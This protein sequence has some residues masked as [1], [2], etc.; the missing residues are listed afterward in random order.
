MK[1]DNGTIEVVAIEKG[2]YG[3]MRQPGDRFM[4]ND[5]EAF[6]WRW[7]STL[8]PRV[9]AKPQPAGFEQGPDDD[10]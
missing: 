4:I 8:D 2:F 5:V 3:K 7:M 9:L 6:S 1:K 10:K